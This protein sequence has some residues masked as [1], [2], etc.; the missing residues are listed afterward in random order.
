MIIESKNYVIQWC[1]FVKWINTGYSCPSCNDAMCFLSATALKQSADGKVWKCRNTVGSVRH[2]VKRSIRKGSWFEGCNLTLEE[3][4][5][6]SY[7]WA[8]RYKMNW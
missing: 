3:I 4:V 8:K 1:Q 2:Q 5:K 7:M 6:F